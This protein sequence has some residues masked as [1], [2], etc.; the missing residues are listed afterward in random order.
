MNDRKDSVFGLKPHLH[1]LYLHH[2]HLHRQQ[3]RIKIPP[4]KS[5][6]CNLIIQIEYSPI[7]NTCLLKIQHHYL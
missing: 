2:H 3:S 5:Y 4:H 7:L 6:P 1:L